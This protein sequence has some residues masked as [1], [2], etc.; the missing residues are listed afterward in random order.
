M[1]LIVVVSA[2]REAAGT[3]LKGH[4]PMCM[5]HCCPCLCLRHVMPLVPPAQAQAADATLN[6][7][8]TLIC[9]VNRVSVVSAPCCLPHMTAMRGKD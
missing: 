1:E 4:S 3:E 2:A 5:R 7:R 8:D 6:L 9:R